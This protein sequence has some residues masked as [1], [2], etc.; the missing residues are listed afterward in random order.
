LLEQLKDHIEE[1]AP[2]MVL[3]GA[4]LEWPEKRC[5]YS[6]WGIVEAASVETMA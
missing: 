2:S 5:S 1:V 4:S 6:D 3:E